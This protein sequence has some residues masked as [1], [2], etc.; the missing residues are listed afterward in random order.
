M[1]VAIS[2]IGIALNLWYLPFSLLVRMENRMAIFAL[3]NITASLSMIGLNIFFVAGLKMG[4]AA[5]I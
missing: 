2:L 1:A 4:A 5:L 3:I